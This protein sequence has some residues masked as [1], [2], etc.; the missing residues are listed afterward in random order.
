MSGDPV[1]VA[2]VPAET[3]AELPAKSS[4]ESE[5]AYVA[6]E[7]RPTIVTPRLDDDHVR[8][9]VPVCKLFTIPEYESAAEAKF[10]SVTEMPV[11]V[12]EPVPAETV[13]VEANTGL[14]VSFTILPVMPEAVTVAQEKTDPLNE[15]GPSAREVKSIAETEPDDSPPE[16]DTS[17]PVATTVAPERTLT[18]TSLPVSSVPL[19]ANAGA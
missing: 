13:P 1:T 5:Y 11:N 18:K 6:P 2:N 12:A 16:A 4:A 17:E 19:R 9:K 3:V 15:Y 7:L 8:E 14:T 10:A